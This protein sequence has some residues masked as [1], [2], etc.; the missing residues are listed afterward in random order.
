LL[1]AICYSG[2]Y[3]SIKNEFHSAL[4]LIPCT[5]CQASAQA[6]LELHGR[7]LEPGLNLNVYISNPERKKERTD[8][9][10]D[11]RE[12]YV[13]GLAKST[14]RADLE[15]LFAQFGTIKDVRM[16][17]DDKGLSKG[18]AF[19]EFEAESSAVQALGVNNHEL[20]KR[21]IGVTL[22]DSRASSRREQPESGQGRKN[23]VRSRSIRLRNL[24]PGTQEGLLQQTLEKLAA[25]KTVEVFQSS[26][27]AVVELEN[28][29]E[30][31]KLLLMTDG[32]QF[33]DRTLT[34][35]EEIFAGNKSNK[36]SKSS[37]KAPAESSSTNSFVPRAAKARPRAGLGHKK[38]L[39]TGA[40]A[41][42][43]AAAP[44]VPAQPS[45]SAQA[46]GVGKD[47]DFFRRMLG[48]A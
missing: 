45:A 10:A 3:I 12:V 35:S 11:Q 17:L 48:N 25:V 24:P 9:G 41:V 15:G 19:I 43:A 32:I 42:V 4:T 13:A 7:E 6:A 44:S 33:G 22:A 47:Q 40:T 31:G 39:G 18:F 8:A 16:A 14:K 2:G 36:S 26:G 30:A 21:R 28:V 34:V 37:K 5:L 23:E 29:A 38:G 1:C 20:K 27:E 46:D